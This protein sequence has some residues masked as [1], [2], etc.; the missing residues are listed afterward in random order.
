VGREAQL[1]RGV[2]AWALTIFTLAVSRVKKL[3][4]P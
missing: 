2:F 1:V 4:G 3:H